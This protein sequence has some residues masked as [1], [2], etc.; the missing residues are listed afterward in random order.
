[1]SIL[2]DA[3]YST[4]QF[5]GVSGHRCEREAL[6]YMQ[7]AKRK[8]MA[9]TLACKTCGTDPDGKTRLLEKLMTPLCLVLCVFL[10]WVVMHRN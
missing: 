5:C 10:A 7:T 9:E 4:T 3:G 8:D 2:A 1:M 6:R